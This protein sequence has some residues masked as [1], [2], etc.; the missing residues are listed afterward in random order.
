VRL[1]GGWS[2][3]TPAAGGRGVSCADSD[4]GCFLMAL[5]LPFTSGIVGSCR[6]LRV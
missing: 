1:E 2:W 5:P 6:R 3:L 4:G